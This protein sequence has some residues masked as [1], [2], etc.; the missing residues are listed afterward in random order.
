MQKI[1]IVLLCLFYGLTQISCQSNEEKALRDRLSRTEITNK[2]PKYLS[3]AVINE[4]QQAELAINRKYIKEV[5]SIVSEN[6]EEKLEEFEE[7]ELGFFVGYKHMFK[8]LANSDEELADYWNLKTS[9]YFSNQSTQEKLHEAYANYNS[10]VQQL[11]NQISKSPQCKSIP[12]EVKFNLPSQEISL[13]KMNQHSYLNIAIEFGTDLAV[14]L[15]IMLIVAIISM[16][17][18]WSGP[19][20]WV[21][22]VITIIASIG[23]SMYNDNRMIDSIREQYQENIEIDNNNI[24]EELDK[25]TNIFYDYIAKH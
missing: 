10:D 2:V 25:S 13:G 16:F 15:L 14:W 1:W 5:N 8:V 22:T 24:L 3:S 19:P 23:L 12:K 4:Y 21:V 9:K 7:N 6:F 20:A 18:V 11:R 17:F